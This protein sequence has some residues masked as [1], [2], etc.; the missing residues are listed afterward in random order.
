M[1]LSSFIYFLRLIKNFLLKNLFI[2]AWDLYIFIVSLLLIGYHLS[3]FI[4]SLLLI[5]YFLHV[6]PHVRSVRDNKM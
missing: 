2:L 1:L 6:I 5:S 3:T 4:V